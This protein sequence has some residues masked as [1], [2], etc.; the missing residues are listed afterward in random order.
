MDQMHFDLGGG[1]VGMAGGSWANGLTASQR[2][3]FPGVESLGMGANK[4]AQAL[5]MLT[6]KSTD[7]NSGFD[8]LGKGLVGQNGNGGLLSFLG[9]ANFKANTTLSAY[10]GAPQGGGAGGGLLGGLF[11]WIG[12]LFGFADGT[13]NAP[14]GWA[15]VGERGPELRK[16]R[17][18][19]VIR[20]N[21]RSMQMAAEAGRGGGVVS[22][23][24]MHF[25]N[26]PAVMHQEES[27]DGNGG[28]RMDI[29]FEEQT[30][31]ASTRRGSASNKALTSLGLSRPMKV[32]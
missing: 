24:E 22:K 13:E 21:S 20:S 3:M 16:L 25:H 10:L 19:D 9:S 23:T 5:D 31:K 8:L 12:K 27:D 11:G 7:L 15:W 29:W 18:G 17:A 28:R 32:R 26:A 2:A 4:A 6:T 14:A 1:K 30:A